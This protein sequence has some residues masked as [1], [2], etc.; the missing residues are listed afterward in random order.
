M[1]AKLAEA[2]Q[3]PG[4]AAHLPEGQKHPEEDASTKKVTQGTHM[5]CAPFLDPGL[6]SEGP[7]LLWIM[8]NDT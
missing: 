7:E 6:G 4:E 3:P 8:L 1:Q 2:Q 5:L